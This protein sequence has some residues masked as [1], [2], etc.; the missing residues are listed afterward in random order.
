MIK[1]IDAHNFCKYLAVVNMISF[2]F[3]YHVHEKAI[4]LVTIPMTISL[5]Q[6]LHSKDPIV[7]KEMFV[8]LSRFILMKLFI[9]WT[10]WPILFT[11]RDMMNRHLLAVLDFIIFT[12]LVN[13][14]LRQNSIAKVD[15]SA[16]WRIWMNKRM[17]WFVVICM[18]TS[19]RKLRQ[20]YLE[21]VRI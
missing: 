15:S 13:Y 2:N 20:Y 21:N 19:F 10:F 17:Q 5:F 12:L 16:S 6:N 4:M 14:L 7:R 18:L 9:I 3:G 8:D 1:K 11:K